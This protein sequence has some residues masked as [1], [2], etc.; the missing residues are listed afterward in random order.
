M[1]NEQRTIGGKTLR[2]RPAQPGDAAPTQIAGSEAAAPASSR[3]VPGEIGGPLRPPFERSPFRPA[4]EPPGPPPE[5][6]GSETVVME[7]EPKTPIPLAWLAVVEGPGAKRGK[8][9][10]LKAETIVGRTQGD[11]TL[12]GDRAMSS[13]HVRIRLEPKEGAAAE[14]EQVFVVYDLATTN[15]TYVG[16]RETYRDDASRVYR[17]VLRDGDYL[18]LGETSLVFKQAD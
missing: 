14:G 5:P 6:A 12:N 11:L 2:D 17:R 4:S 10:A 18:L 13:Q 8:L 7:L 16:T 1:V 9:V 15:G 3:T